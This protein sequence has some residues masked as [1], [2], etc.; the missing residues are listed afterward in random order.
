MCRV[1]L[2][3]S[4]HV[5]YCRTLFLPFCPHFLAL[6]VS[7][8][9]SLIPQAMSDGFPPFTC[10]PFWSGPDGMACSLKPTT[11]W[12]PTIIGFSMDIAS[13]LTIPKGSYVDGKMHVSAA[14]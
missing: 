4:F 2:A 11:P 6:S 8:R 3:A 9:I 14:A 7:H 1:C 13:R 12:A 5:K 10:T